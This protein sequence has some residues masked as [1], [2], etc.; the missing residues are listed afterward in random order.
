MYPWLPES[1][2]DGWCSKAMWCNYNNGE[3]VDVVL[4]LES[5]YFFGLKM[6]EFT[7]KKFYNVLCF[8]RTTN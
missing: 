7:K 4:G 3:T 5:F 8:S 2:D 6:M 1:D